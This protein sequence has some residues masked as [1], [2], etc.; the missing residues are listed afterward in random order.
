MRSELMPDGFDPLSIETSQMEQAVL[1]LLQG[2]TMRQVAA[3]LQVNESTI[4][5]WKNR[6]EWREVVARAQAEIIGGAR[7]R[8]IGMVHKALN[9][10][11]G[12]V[13]DSSGKGAPTE[14]SI[15][16]G[17]LDRVGVEVQQ[18][19]AEGIRRILTRV[20]RELAAQPRPAPIV[21]EEPPQEPQERP[22]IR[23]VT[24]P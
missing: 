24:R 20:P 7:M 22:S 14:A 11:D 21:P 4:Y 9:K 8:L 23:I 1:L 12:L 10:L 13:E 6:P 2:R 15:A 19:Q 5:R 18:Q 16:W 17:I 3:E